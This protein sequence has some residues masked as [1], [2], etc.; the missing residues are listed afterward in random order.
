MLN[1]SLSRASKPAIA[2]ETRHIFG[3][4]PYSVQFQQSLLTLANWRSGL[5]HDTN[6][7]V[8]WLGPKTSTTFGHSWVRR[9]RWVCSS[10]GSRHRIVGGFGRSVP[11]ASGGW[12]LPSHSRL[13]MCLWSRMALK[14]SRPPCCRSRSRSNGVHWPFLFHSPILCGAVALS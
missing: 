1:T 10:V 12:L 13:P 14:P 8:G 5:G 4:I 7:L 11:P 9:G 2:G 3:G 6:G